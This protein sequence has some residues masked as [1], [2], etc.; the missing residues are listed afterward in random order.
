MYDSGCALAYNGVKRFMHGSF[1]HQA[2]S[3]FAFVQQWW[4]PID[5]CMSRSVSVSRM[6]RSLVF[7]FQACWNDAHMLARWVYVKARRQIG[8]YLRASFSIDSDSLNGGVIARYLAFLI[9]LCVALFLYYFVRRSFNFLWHEI[10]FLLNFDEKT[11]LQF[12][13][14]TWFSQNSCF[15]FSEI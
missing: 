5:S 15:L 3:S 8:K 9:L 2:R 10:I 7:S 13:E 12:T 14:Y 6:M 11:V 1:N 4:D